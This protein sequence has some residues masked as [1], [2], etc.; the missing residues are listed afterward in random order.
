MRAS[1]RCGLNPIALAFV[2]GEIK[3]GRWSCNW[4]EA[5]ITTMIPLLPQEL[6]VSWSLL[7]WFDRLSH[8]ER[9]A[10]IVGGRTTDYST[11]MSWRSEAFPNT[12]EHGKRST[13]PLTYLLP[14]WAIR[15]IDKAGMILVWHIKQGMDYSILPTCPLRRR[16][17]WRNK[18]AVFYNMCAILS[19]FFSTFG[20]HSANFFFYVET[21]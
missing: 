21:P 20:L 1:L 9:L 16:K 3:L 15:I 5:I 11:I 13:L 19:V 8:Q 18:L 12:T 17:R 2:E 7:D 14:S 10:L 6:R 4:R